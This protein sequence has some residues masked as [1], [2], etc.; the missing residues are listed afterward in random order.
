VDDTQT[1]PGALSLT[2]GSCVQRS[3][4]GATASEIAI[5]D[6]GVITAPDRRAW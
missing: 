5:T 3:S 4:G 1:P 2:D 6:R